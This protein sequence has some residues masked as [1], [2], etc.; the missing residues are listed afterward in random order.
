MRFEEIFRVCGLAPF[1]R[2]ALAVQSLVFD[3]L[4]AS[5]M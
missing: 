4:L 2:Q 1:G 5:L 3:F